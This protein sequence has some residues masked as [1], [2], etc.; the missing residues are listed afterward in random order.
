MVFVLSHNNIHLIDIS[1]F[2]LG[3]SFDSSGSIV[4]MI[5]GVA[6]QEFRHAHTALS[7]GNVRNP[8][9]DVFRWGYPLSSD[10]RQLEAHAVDFTRVFNIVVLGLLFIICQSEKYCTPLQ[11]FPLKLELNSVIFPHV[12]LYVSVGCCVY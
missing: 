10:I 2:V 5:L 9:S 7:F 11:S 4:F 8:R 6:G 12:P 3:L 1:V